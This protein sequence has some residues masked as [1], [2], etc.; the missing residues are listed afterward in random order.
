[1]DNQNEELKI[2]NILIVRDFV[3]VFPKDLP[4]L[5][6]DREIEFA[7]DLVSSTTPISI[8]P[9]HMAPTELKELKL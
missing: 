2:D 5:P 8:A 3:D 7:I 4:R 1:M 9:N 6:F